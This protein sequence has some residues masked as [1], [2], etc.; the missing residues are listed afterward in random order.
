MKFK[1]T[2]NYVA[3]DDLMLAVNAAILAMTSGQL[4]I[5]VAS[6]FNGQGSATA[7]ML[8]ENY[9]LL[10]TALGLGLPLLIVVSFA[11]YICTNSHKNT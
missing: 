9:M 4:P 2:Q 3:T 1:G 5:R 8:R 7:F 10:M 6:S 11:L